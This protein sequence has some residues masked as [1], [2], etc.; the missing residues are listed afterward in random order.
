MRP[1]RSAVKDAPAK[2]AAKQ[3]GS[4]STKHVLLGDIGATN[5]RLALLTN[6]VL[7]PIKSFDV[8][9]FARFADAA[10]IFLKGH[11]QQIENTKAILAVAG[12]IE[13]QRSTLTNCS[14]IIDAR[15]LYETFGLQARIVNDFEAVALSLPSLAL[16]DVLKIGGGESE[17]GAPMAVLGPG[18][19]LGVAC[20]VPGPGKPVVIPSEG[21]HATLA[22]MCDR[23]D[24]IIKQLR[25]QF[26]HVSAERLISGEGLQNIYQAIVALEGLALAP[27]SA[28]DI[29]KRALSGDCRVA[30]EALE[31]FCAFLGSFA[32]NVALTFG[33]RG[34]AY[35]AGGI[36]PRILDFIAR[37]TF[38]NRFEA[39]GRFRSYLE[40][41]PSY[42]I[43]HPA[44]A[45]VGLK[46]VADLSWSPERACP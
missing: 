5:A 16:P 22:G 40:T 34:G 29:T 2:L 8:A 44:A 36:S 45:F 18:T 15:E 46:S 20:L 42:V 26:E 41:I 9:S 21:G 1:P 4:I 31:K 32:G 23:E 11:C 30:H 17:S 6:G 14:W 35:I 7:S 39:K 10:A 43:V 19:G 12:P 25:R 38:R 24:E 37:S 28:A 3:E 33:A 13:G 27:R